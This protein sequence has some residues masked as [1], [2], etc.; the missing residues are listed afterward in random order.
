[1]QAGRPRH[2][3]YNFAWPPPIRVGLF[4][5]AAWPRARTRGDR[6]CRSRGLW[7]IATLSVLSPCYCAHCW[8]KDCEFAPL[9]PRRRFCALP[10]KIEKICECIPGPLT[11]RMIERV[12]SS[13]NST[14][15]WVTPPREPRREAIKSAFPSPGDIVVIALCWGLWSLGVGGGALHCVPVRPRT[16][17]TLTSLTGCL[18]ASILTDV[19]FLGFRARRTGRDVGVDGGY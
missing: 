4:T 15:T 13:M 3:H 2:P 7:I 1:M 11:L 6:E 12:W 19:C 5:A 9:P 17:V 14:R 8:S 18:E 10:G 16:R